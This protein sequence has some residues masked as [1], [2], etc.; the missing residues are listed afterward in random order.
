M[1]NLKRMLSMVLALVMALALTTMAFAAEDTT[2]LKVNN[3]SDGSSYKAYQIMSLK[4]TGSEAGGNAAYS[5]VLNT[6]YTEAVRAAL[7]AAGATN[8]PADLTINYLNT[9]LGDTIGND[10]A[11]V[12]LFANGLYEQVKSMAPEQTL[13]ATEA[14][15]GKTVPQGYYLIVETL[16]TDS[17]DMRSLV[18][19]D[20]AGNAEADINVKK[21]NPTVEK[22]VEGEDSAI[23]YVGQEL[24]FT[25]TANLTK[26]TQEYKEFN[27]YFEDTLGEGLTYKADS[28][29]V[30]YKADATS[31][32]EE[33]TT[34]TGVT[35]TPNG[36]SLKID[37]KGL[38]DKVAYAGLTANSTIYATYVATINEKA[39]YGDVTAAED[40]NSNLVVL[41]YTNDP[42]WSSTETPAVDE[43]KGETEGGDKVTV[44]TIELDIA[45]TDGTDPLKGA[46]FTLYRWNPDTV[47]WEAVAI[48]EAV[49]ADTTD[50]T[51]GGIGIGKYRLVESKVPDGRVQMEDKFFEV[52]GTSEL[53]AD[54]SAKIVT[55]AIKTLTPAT[56]VQTVGADIQQIKTQAEVD[57]LTK[58][59]AHDAEH[60]TITANSAVVNT[61]IINETGIRLPA[62]GGQGTT[63]L[64]IIGGIVLLVA[65]GGCYIYMRKR[66][67]A[68]Q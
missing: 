51:F 10:A 12:R 19:L 33:I 37:V 26:Y 49:T 42:Y 52:E 29:K 13:T 41:K 31:T 48:K 16:A 53:Q 32:P 24:N 6:K 36:Q 46:D 63:M 8:I 38:Q 65:L 25:I 66:N 28:C 5:Y 61:T 47:A 44:I 20:T 2:T 58:G 43:P 4:M 67:A 59:E 17:N 50:F 57:A 3:G 27:L 68:E 45:K 15:T 64:Y 7:Q 1:K 14:A 54:D 39:S 9:A 21:E 55:L 30:Y 18:M 56:A 35:V 60:Y 22:K 40:K 62:T 34:K 23:A 11:K